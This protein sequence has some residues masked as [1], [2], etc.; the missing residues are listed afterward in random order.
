MIKVKEFACGS[1]RLADEQI[2]AFLKEVNGEYID[3][4]ITG[5]ENTFT[6]QCDYIVL[7]IYKEKEKETLG[8]TLKDVM[9]QNKR[10]RKIIENVELTA[11]NKGYDDIYNLLVEELEDEDKY[12][13]PVANKITAGTIDV[14]RIAENED[15]AER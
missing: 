5:V 3:L 10:Y 2:N 8:E 14:S 13:I 7:L 15:D 11:Q 9:E 4:K 6:T 12:G 1:S